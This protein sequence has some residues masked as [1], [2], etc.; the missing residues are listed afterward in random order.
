LEKL[1]AQNFKTVQPGLQSALPFAITTYRYVPIFTSVALARPGAQGGYVYDS[2]LIARGMVG[3]GE[4]PQQGDTT[5]VSSLQY[6][7]D[8]DVNNELI[9]DRTR[10]LLGVNGTKWVGIPANLNNGPANAEL[11]NAANWQL[12]FQSANRVGAVCIRTNG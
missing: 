12:I 2:Y 6:W 8:R 1:D 3:Y 4:K 7:R 5:D 9:W 11:Q 10:F